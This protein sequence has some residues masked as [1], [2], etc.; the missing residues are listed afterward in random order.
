MDNQSNS[1][2]GCNRHLLRNGLLA[3][4]IVTLSN[5]HSVSSARALARKARVLS[6][7][8]FAA[9]TFTRSPVSR[10][11]FRDLLLGNDASSSLRADIKFRLRG[12]TVGEDRCLPPRRLMGLQR[13]VSGK[14]NRLLAEA[15]NLRAI[16]ARDLRKVSYRDPVSAPSIS[17]ARCFFIIAKVMKSTIG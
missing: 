11:A 1:S 17:L 2:L 8:E 16:S 7:R 6:V 12:K 9:W 13:I 4:H 5:L 10:S 3:A 15:Q 14:R